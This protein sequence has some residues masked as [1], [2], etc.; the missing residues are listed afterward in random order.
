[1]S[2]H[3]W[4]RPFPRQ[5]HLVGAMRRWWALGPLVAISAAGLLSYSSA[6]PFDGGPDTAALR[7]VVPHPDGS[8]RRLYSIGSPESWFEDFGSAQLV[9]GMAEVLLDPGFAGLVRTDDYHVFLTPYGDSGGLYV[10]SQGLTSFRV[11]EQGGGTSNLKF[12]YAVVA[13]RKD[14]AES[15]LEPIALPSP[16][17][18]TPFPTRPRPSG[19]DFTRR[20]QELETRSTPSPTSEPMPTRAP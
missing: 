16:V 10:S 4:K 14:V 11:Q 2:E 1:M 9:R 7:Q 5:R 17:Q 12:S 6:A 3:E 19:S 18:V 15:R 20:L 8:H 13:K